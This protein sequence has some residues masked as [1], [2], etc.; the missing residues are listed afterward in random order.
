MIYK[1]STLFMEISF[2]SLPLHSTISDEPY[3]CQFFIQYWQMAHLFLK[4]YFNF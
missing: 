3:D 1:V 2:F 4:P